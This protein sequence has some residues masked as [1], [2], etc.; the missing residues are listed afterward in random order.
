MTSEK[1]QKVIFEKV[2]ANPAN[3]KV[4]IDRIVKSKL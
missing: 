2:G 4:D 1:V 3:S